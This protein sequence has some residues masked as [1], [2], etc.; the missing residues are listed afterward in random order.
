MAMPTAMSNTPPP[1]PTG[2]NPSKFSDQNP[3]KFSDQNP[4][5][6]R[7]RRS[8]ALRGEIEARDREVKQLRSQLALYKSSH[9][10][11]V[12]TLTMVRVVNGV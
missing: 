4:N 11:M 9:E 7:L 10:A 12:E 2:E 8:S 6:A 5:I 3:S 1:P